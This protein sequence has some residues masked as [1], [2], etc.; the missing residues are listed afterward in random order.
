MP[1]VLAAGVVVGMVA[2]DTVTVKNAPPDQKL[3]KLRRQVEHG[4]VSSRGHSYC[5]LL[6]PVLKSLTRSTSSDSILILCCS[7]YAMIAMDPH[8]AAMPTHLSTNLSF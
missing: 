4:A 1:M 5:S 6:P 2:W 7:I 3:A 8:L